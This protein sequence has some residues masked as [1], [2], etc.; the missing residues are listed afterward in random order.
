METIEE[1]AGQTTKTTGW[2]PIEQYD[3]LI[4]HKTDLIIVWMGGFP[5]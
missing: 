4:I 2:I 5:L 1:T 3:D